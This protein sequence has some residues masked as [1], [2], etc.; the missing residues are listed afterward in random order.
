[1]MALAAYKAS[2]ALLRDFGESDHLQTSLRGAKDFCERARVKS[3]KTLEYTLLKSYPDYGLQIDGVMVAESSD[4]KGSLFLVTPLAG[5]LNFQ[6]GWPFFCSVITLVTKEETRATLV[7]DPLRDEIFW[8]SKEIGTFCDQRRLRVSEAQRN[9]HILLGLDALCVTYVDFT[10]REIAIE[11]RLSGCLPLDMAYVS[12]GRLDGALWH[13]FS[14]HD[15]IMAELLVQGARGLCSKKPRPEVVLTTSQGGMPTASEN[16]SHTDGVQNKGS[17]LMAGNASCFA[18]LS[19][20][21]A[22]NNT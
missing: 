17:V 15:Q 8:S 12:A 20:M 18:W 13:S 7:F 14:L 9:N 10:R 2:R 11:G 22:Q 16:S 19:A 1:M 3:G 4:P 5:G 21:W 6:R